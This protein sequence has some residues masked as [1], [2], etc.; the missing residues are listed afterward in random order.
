MKECIMEPPKELEATDVDDLNID[1]LKE[2]AEMLSLTKLLE[3]LE[4]PTPKSKGQASKIP[5]VKTKIPKNKD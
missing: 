3:G 2:Q 4:E 5:R 1:S